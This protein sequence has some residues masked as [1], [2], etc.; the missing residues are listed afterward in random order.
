MSRLWLIAKRE[1]LSY[2]RT[3]GFWLSLMIGPI[4]GLIGG[5][6]P[7]FLEHSAPAPRLAVIDL[8]APTGAGARLQAILTA[9]PDFKGQHPTAVIRPFPAQ[10][11]LA[12]VEAQLKRSLSDPNG[13]ID[14]AVV[15]TGAADHPEVRFW[16]RDVADNREVQSAVADAASTDLRLNRLKASGIS[17]ALLASIETAKAEVV[18][19]S[20]K[21][22]KSGKAMHDIAPTLAAFG[23]AFLLWMLV[24]TGAGILLNSVIEEKSNRILELLMTSASTVEILAG[25]IAGVAMLALTVMALWA[26]MGLYALNHYAPP[27]IADE[28]MKGLTANHAEVWF[29]AFFGGGYLMYAAIVAAIGAFCETPREAQTLFG[30]LMIVLTIP[31]IFMSSAIRHPELPMLRLMSW[32]PPFTPFLMTARLASN[33]P[34]WELGG[35]L[36]LMAAF[37]AGVV[38]FSGR[39]FRAGALST[40]KLTPA[41]FLGVLV[42]KE[43]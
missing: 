35:S 28:L 8:A 13:P 30:P 29:L 43:A 10:G 2:L 17:P 1:Y 31:M 19:F 38:W 39:A 36:V 21:H 41:G 25:K 7:T 15:L 18:R 32:L 40:A 3:P 22:G 20:A 9:R 33:P 6:G 37:A 5:F 12:A 16:S 14:A 4:A 23:M 27:G 34:L 26:G 42:R 24:V 11:D